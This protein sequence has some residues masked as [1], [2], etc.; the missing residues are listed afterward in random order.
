[1]PTFADRG[2]R[3]VSATDPHG[4]ILGFLDPEPLLF[5]SSSSSVI[6]TRLCGPRSRPTTSQ[7]IWYR[8]VLWICS[9]E[10]WSLDPRGG[11]VH[12]VSELKSHTYKSDKM[13]RRNIVH[14]RKFVDRIL[15]GEGY[16]NSSYGLSRLTGRDSKKQTSSGNNQNSLKITPNFECTRSFTD[17]KYFGRGGGCFGSNI[18]SRFRGSMTNN[19]GF[20][21]GWLDLLT[22]SLQLQPIITAHN[23]WLFKTHSVSYWTTSVFSSAVTD[24]VL[25]Y[26]SV[27]SSASVVRWLTLHSWTLSFC[28]LLRLNDWTHEW[29]NEFWVWVTLRLTV[30]QSA[31]LGVE[32]RPGLMTRYYE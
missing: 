29:L 11:L 27:T 28:I 15:A 32:P 9:Q 16:Q 24:L 8:R 20:W 12:L 19:N 22:P 14:Q 31:C 7:K 23:Q 18:L 2:C 25:I 30:S 1:V 5:H 6:L 3:V 17:Y 10:L 13:K 21:F 4:R 26:E